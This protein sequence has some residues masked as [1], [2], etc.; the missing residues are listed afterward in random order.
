M[1]RPLK[2]PSLLTLRELERV[3]PLIPD[4]TVFIVEEKWDGSNITVYKGVF[5]TRN[6]HEI[7]EKVGGLYRGLQS[8]PRD[9]VEAMISLS[10]RYQLFFELGGEKNSPAG[11]K[12][13]WE[14]EWDYRVFD[15]YDHLEKRFL[16]VEEMLRLT[17]QYR[18]KTIEHLIKAPLNYVLENK[19]KLLREDYKVYE[20][21]VA[22]TYDQELL[23]RLE[24]KY[25]LSMR[26]KGL[27][28]FKVKH[29][30]LARKPD[31]YTEIM[32]AINKAHADMG[33][34]LLEKPL[35]EIVEV[36]KKYVEEE[37]R[38]HG[39]QVPGKKKIKHAVKTYLKRYSRLKT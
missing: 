19:E 30:E 20:G 11:Y 24:E 1:D 22:K 10:D 14:G 37:A 32:G 3:L 12:E 21:Y 8:L 35:N 15:I 2:Y 25:P 7:T 6:L 9:H 26:N 18:L 28:G 13:P 39:F 36:V 4:D 5:Y 16:E 34:Q 29:E 27:F 31:I 23:R 38:K 33:D 17:R